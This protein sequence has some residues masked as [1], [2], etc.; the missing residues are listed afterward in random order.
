MAAIIVN[1]GRV[2]LF[3]YIVGKDT[4]T[5]PLTLHYYV[6]Q[7]T[8]TAATV[9]GDLTECTEGGYSSIALTGG[10]WTASG[11]STV[12]STQQTTTFTASPGTQTIYGYYYTLTTTG[13]LFAVE[14][15]AVAFPVNANGDILRMTPEIDWG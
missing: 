5:E 10:S 3:D 11:T 9:I 12:Y 14:D 7:P 1:T 13:T 2:V 8:V 4:T 15:L 6:N